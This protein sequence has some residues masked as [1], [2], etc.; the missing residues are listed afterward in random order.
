MSVELKGEF[1][2]KQMSLKMKQAAAGG[3]ES[4]ITKEASVYY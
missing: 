1:S 4:T 2:I 3:C